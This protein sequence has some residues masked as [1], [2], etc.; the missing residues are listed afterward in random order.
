VRSEWNGDQQ[1]T[2]GLATVETSCGV[3]TALNS[4]RT[5]QRAAGARRKGEMQQ[6]QGEP[7]QV[8]R[9]WEMEA[10]AR[11]TGKRFQRVVDIFQ[12]EGNARVYPWYE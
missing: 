5:E 12:Q 1:P 6:K 8:V 9:L 3:A 10:E 7:Q 2:E 11:Q 4:R